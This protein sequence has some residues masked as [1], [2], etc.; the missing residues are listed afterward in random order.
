VG[1]LLPAL[2]LL[3]FLPDSS[4]IARNAC[5]GS[6]DCGSCMGSVR[7]AGGM[8][9]EDRR[10]LWIM[11][12]TPVLTVPAYLVL[13]FLYV[14]IPMLICGLLGEKCAVP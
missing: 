12:G 7:I 1:C 8:T 13:R 9:K 10:A 6:G 5:N 4:D 3:Q 11:V 2:R 14:A